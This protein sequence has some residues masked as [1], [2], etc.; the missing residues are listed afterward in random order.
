MGHH[1]FRSVRFQVTALATLIVAGVLA[2]TALALIFTQQRSLTAAVDDG[3]HRR[4]DDLAAL[5]ATAVP[6]SLP[7]SEDDTAAQLVAP[8]GRVIVSSPNI[9]ADMPMAPDPGDSVVV[10]ER[11]VAGV[12]DSFRVLSRSATSGDGRL[13]IH[14][15]TATDDVTDS[16]GILRTSL[17]VII[18]AVLVVLAAAIWW[19]VGRALRP[20]DVITDEVNA[21]SQSA[22]D[23]RVPVP[24][25]GDEISRLAATMNTMLD[26][27]EEGVTRLQ[28]F[29]ADASHELRSPLTRIRSE[30][31]VNVSDPDSSDLAATH[32]SVLEETIAMQELIED[33]L[34]VARTDGG[35]QAIRRRP[36]DLDDLVM[37]E[38]QRLRAED[39][40]AVDVSGVA[41]VQVMG[42]ASQLAR[43]VRNLGGNAARH[44]SHRVEFGLT[45]LDD[46]ALLTVTD[47]GPGIPQHEIQR[48]FERFTR[49][50]EARS[51][52]A[53]GSG[54][55]LAIVRD[56]VARHNGTVEV[57]VDNAPGARLIVRLP[58]A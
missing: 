4:A 6:D 16:V 11:H 39:A 25:T 17:L 40:V 14:V 21:I 50:D 38:A 7:G 27:L 47:D 28:R 26:R 42:D 48:V 58:I 8:D 32:R 54:L 35:E 13:I 18:P 22:L 1:R 36:V 30:L 3:L 9:A 57:D 56:I 51:R 55:G 15:A 5:V 12:E 44:A 52:E 31:E 49:L 24:Q 46:A 37:A 20:V 33:L 45:E 10:A 29:V 23:R 41:A 43:V 53:G 19:L 34:F 2:A